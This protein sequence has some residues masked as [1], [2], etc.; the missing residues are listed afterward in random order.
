MAID[1]LFIDGIH[2]HDTWP[3]TSAVVRSHLARSG[4]FRL[5]HVRA[6]VPELFA[7]D[8]SGFAAVIPY[9]CPPPDPDREPAW[10]AATRS[11]LEGYVRGGGGLVIIHAASNA[12]ARWPEYNRMIGLG[13]WGGRDASAGA[14]LY[15]N[16]R[17]Q[18]VR[19][20]E[21]GPAG[22]HEPELEYTIDVRAPE[23]PIMR[24]MPR[25]WLHPRDE[26]YGFLRGPGVGVEVLASAFSG[27]TSEGTQRHEPVVMTIAYGA[28]RVFHTTL[29][30]SSRALEGAGLR[31]L[32]TRGTEW[33][34][35]GAVTQ[36][37][38]DD[39]P[40]AQAAAPRPE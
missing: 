4:R 11:A 22:H 15:L 18:V 38:P 31:T 17:G 27:K 24:G 35:T 21:P 40:A 9:Y 32:I 20:S 39:F 19:S 37:L 3:E 33:A 23:H 8:F 25:A 34:A 7:A 16:E 6:P 36:P 5:E 28:G 12:F 13:G 10:P 30:H 14:Y 1:V 29:G 2:T 26:V